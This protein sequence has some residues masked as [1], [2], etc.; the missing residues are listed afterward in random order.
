MTDV[1]HGAPA[2]VDPVR[3]WII[4]AALAVGSF[5]FVTVETLPIGLLSDLAAGLAV[6]EGTVGQ[7]VTV[8]AF[9]VMAA[10][11]PLTV[12]FSRFPRRALLI[13]VFAVFVAATTASALAGN[14][15]V[16]L[17][18]RA[19]LAMA[20][21]LFWSVAVSLAGTLVPDARKGRAIALVYAGISFA[22]LLGVPGGV[23]LGHW[24][25]WRWAMG[26]LP[27]AGL[28]VVAVL[29]AFLPPVQGHEPI[30][31]RRV[32]ALLGRTRVRTAMIA[33]T[34]A[35]TGTYV[36]FTYISPLLQ[37]VGH[38]Q[39]DMVSVFLLLF[40]LAGVGGNALAGV[41]VDRRPYT[42]VFV[43][44]GGMLTVVVAFAALGGRTPVTVLTVVAWGLCGS[45][46]PTVFTA[47]ALRL[48][49]ADREAITALLVIAVNFGLGAGALVGGGLLNGAGT[50]GVTSA[51]AL[52]LATALAA[53]V[54]G[55]R[56]RP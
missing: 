53:A 51:A 56:Q 7:L 25:G 38:V 6:S 14:Y 45:A 26:V 29:A 44:V 48:A 39:P 2:V 49:P 1:R 46:M 52:L 31:A 55:S 4:V 21:A 41:L 28:V 16:L 15:V 11:V 30:R 19:V 13:G 34:A 12:A 10:A 42:T 9:C 36:A 32:F 20:Q 18:V 17:V 5:L 23:A 43:A 33:I 22:Q 40:G 37:R 54:L 35:F 27:V 50:S 8:Y 3:A 24:L 47:W